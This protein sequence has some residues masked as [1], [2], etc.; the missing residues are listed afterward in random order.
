M[1]APLPRLRRVSTVV[2]V[3]VDDGSASR[4]AAEVYGNNAHGGH[5]QYLKVPANT[6][7]PL[8]DE[9]SFSAGAAIAC[10]SGTAY[11]A[12]RRMNLSGNHHLD[13]RPGPGGGGHAICQGDGRARDRARH[14]PAAA[15]AR[16][17]VRRRRRGQP[18]L[19]RS[20]G[21]DQGPHP[22][23]IRRPHARHLEQPGCAPERDPLHQG[24]GHDVLRRRRRRRPHR[25]LAASVAPAIDADGVG[26]SPTSCR[27]N[28]RDFRSSAA[29]TSIGCSPIAGRSTRRRR[30]IDCSTNRSTARACS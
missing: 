14:Q 21:R 3:G 1:A 16:Q 30:P 24:V 11:G 4:C 25:C 2:P 5:A 10:G 17:G 27:R 19:E 22:R 15:G 29:S 23:P 13:L 12:L 7:V 6:L 20:G 26:R 18:R 8:P 28:V 9:L